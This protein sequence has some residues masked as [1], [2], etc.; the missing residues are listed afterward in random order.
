MRKRKEKNVSMS[1]LL[2]SLKCI[3]N[4]KDSRLKGPNSFSNHVQSDNEDFLC[5]S[6][7]LLP[8]PHVHLSQVRVFFSPPP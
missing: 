1:E 2:C 6:G 4:F 5:A 8:F 3:R 7:S